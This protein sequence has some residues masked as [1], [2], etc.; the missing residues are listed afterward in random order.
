MAAEMVSSSEMTDGPVLSV[1]NKRFRALRK[2]QNCILLMEESLAQGKS[3]NKEQEE[4]LR[5]CAPNLLSLLAS[6]SSRSFANRSWPPSPRKYLSP[7]K[8]M[9]TLK[10]RL[11]KT[12]LKKTR[13]KKP[14]TPGRRSRRK[15]RVFLKFLIC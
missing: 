3:L 12:Q 10:P 1:I 14:G 9:K 13:L 5:S 2:K 11:E 4:T 15:R 8:N 6:T 7:W